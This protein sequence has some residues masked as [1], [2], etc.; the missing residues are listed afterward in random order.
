MPCCPETCAMPYRYEVCRCSWNKACVIGPNTACE[1]VQRL[2]A[3]GERYDKKIALRAFIADLHH[4]HGLNLKPKAREVA[5][6]GVHGG[7]GLGRLWWRSWWQMAEPSHLQG[8][9]FLRAEHQREL[10]CHFNA[11][12]SAPFGFSI[13]MD[14]P[15]SHVLGSASRLQK[16]WIWTMDRLA[17]K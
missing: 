2:L 6:L 12:H 1:S 17:P 14:G 7:L 5:S 3:L 13:S 9:F 8:N 16:G 4:L 15:C 10:A 11:S